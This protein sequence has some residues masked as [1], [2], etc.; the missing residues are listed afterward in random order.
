MIL[1]AIREEGFTRISVRGEDWDRPE[2]RRRV[3]QAGLAVIHVEDLLDPA[4]ARGVLAQPVRL[5]REF[6]ARLAEAMGSLPESGV[7]SFSLDF[8]LSGIEHDGGRRAA[9][10][11]LL[12]EIGPE[13]F[14]RNLRLLL[15]VRIPAAADVD[16]ERIPG[17][18]REAMSPHILLAAEIHPHECAREA[19]PMS[20]LRPIR[21]QAVLA[22]MEYDAE[23][24]NRLTEALLRPWL[25]ALAEMGLQDVCFRPH[26]E[27]LERVFLELAG[28]RQVLA[29]LS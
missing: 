16:V 23:A 24:G 20:W 3:A 27:G 15:P 1:G 14:R 12:R 9:L 19:A 11:A 8:D 18:L 22:R 4:V 29:R 25:A 26:A 21:F 13:L 2:V 10:C 17:L 28:V 6:Q 5:R 7:P